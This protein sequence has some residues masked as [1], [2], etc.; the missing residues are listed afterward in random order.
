MKHKI[1]VDTCAWLA[2][3]LKN[4][5]NHKIAKNFLKQEIKKNS[6]I[7]TSN[8]V[9][10]EAVTRLR[11]DSGWSNT[12]KFIEF[13]KNSIKSNC[14]IEFFVDE[15][16]ELDSFNLLKK[17]TDKKLSLTDASIIAICKKYKIHTIFTF[18]SDFQK[19]GISISP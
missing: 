9:I 19:L 11:Y 12:S 7:C 15:Q 14:L 6:L 17:Y 4:D 18:D 8:Y 13:I 16:I 5:I 2:H 3:F 10:D 1:F